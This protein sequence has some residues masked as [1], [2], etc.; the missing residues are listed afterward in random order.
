MAEKKE[1]KRIRKAY[2]AYR[3]TEE[4]A[5]P[6]WPDSEELRP[7][8]RRLGVPYLMLLLEFYRTVQPS[9]VTLEDIE[10]WNASSAAQQV[11]AE[12]WAREAAAEKA[13]A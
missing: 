2:E 9:T 3:L 6:D 7:I 12:A 1:R 13:V 8:A 4:L 10:E 5:P 11:L